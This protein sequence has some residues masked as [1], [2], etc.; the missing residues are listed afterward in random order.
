MARR[1]FRPPFVSSVIQS[2]ERCGHYDNI[3][4]IIKVKNE[5]SVRRSIDISA[6]ELDLEPRPKLTT[7]SIMSNE[8]RARARAGEKATRV[9]DLR[10]SIS[11]P[12]VAP[13]GEHSVSHSRG[14]T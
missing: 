11:V 2:K 14:N 13:A 7:R 12:C 9:L 5:K 8:V 1:T 6:A 4:F 3:S 10:T